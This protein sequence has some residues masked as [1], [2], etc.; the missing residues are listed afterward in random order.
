MSSSTLLASSWVPLLVSF[1]TALLVGLMVVPMVRHYALKAGLVDQ[2]GGRKMHSTPV[3]RLGGI[4]IYVAFLSGLGVLGL[5]MGH[6]PISSPGSLGLLAGGAMM[7]MLG[8]LDDLL[9]LSPYVKLLGQ[10]LACL[11]AF[12]LGVSID[13]LDLPVSKILVLNGLALPVTMGWMI[14]I[15]NAVNFIDGV[16]GLAAGVSTL[17]SLTLV[18]VA[19]FTSQ[20]EA[21]L[22]ASLLAGA[23]LSFLVYNLPPARLFMG[24]SGALFIGFTLSAIAITGVL[25]TYTVVMLTPILVLAVPILDITYSTLRRVLTGRN[26]FIAD[27]DHLHHR[28]LKT[29]LPP[30][31]VVMV[32]YSVCLASGLLVGHYVNSLALYV[33][34]AVGLIALT[35]PLY[36]LRRKWLPVVAPS[37]LTHPDSPDEAVDDTVG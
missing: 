11:V 27:A 23:S 34:L 5:V 33:G 1:F 4:G 21:A 9:D 16:D 28:L 3:P 31:R 19:L 6:S 12:G 26:P 29:G 32:F 24:D 15:S 10:F 18:V 20:P 7:F 2:P 17:A 35:I 37:G 14:G 25:K 22:L 36:L 13:A 30:S 8:L